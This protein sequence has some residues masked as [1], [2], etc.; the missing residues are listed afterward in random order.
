MRQKDL[1]NSFPRQLKLERHRRAWSQARLAELLATD[2]KTV[3]RWERGVALPA[4]YLREHLCQLLDKTPQELG[5]L[6]EETLVATP[7][8][9]FDPSIPLPP[10]ISL[11]GR[12]EEMTRLK[13]RLRD[14]NSIALAALNG[15]PGVGKTA[16][17]IAL[18]HDPDI[19]AHFKDGILWAGLGPNPNI[20]S[21]VSRWGTLLDMSSSE[22]NKL[23]GIEA[24]AEAL[25]RIIGLRTML[26]VIDDAWTPESALALKVGGPTCAHLVTTRLPAVA[27]QIAVD[28][29]ITIG[30]LHDEE[31]LTLLRALAPQ[32]VEKEG[33][34]VRELL[35]AVGGLPLAL[36]LIGNYLRVQS[37]TGQNRRILSALQRLSNT[38]ERLN[39]SAPH[40]PIE[41]HPSHPGDT[42]LSLHTIIA[43]SDQRLDSRARQAFYS[44]AAF[45]AKPNSFSEEAALAVADCPVEVLDLLIDAGLLESTSSDRYT[46]H[47]TIAD[48]ALLQLSEATA[49]ERLITYIANFV[50]IHR[51]DYEILESESNTIVAAL[52]VATEQERYVGLIRIICSL[53]PF[54]LSRG[55]YQLAEAHLHR[56]YDAAITQNDHHNLASILFYL[57]EMLMKQGQYE[58]AVQYLQ[59]GLRE[60]RG[61]GDQSRVC[62]ILAHLGW[63]TWKKGAIIQAEAYL[64]EG[65]T[66][67]RQF[68]YQEQA[69]SLLR[70][71][72]SVS[73]SQGNYAQ[74]E[75]YLRE[76][77]ALASQLRD[78]EQR[79]VLL[80]DLGVT[81]TV[82]GE[83]GQAEQT[84]LEAL[85]IARQLGHQEW[86]SLSLFN[87]G[88]ILIDQQRYTRAKEVFL[89]GLTLAQQIHHQE[90]TGGLLINLGNVTYKEN[91]SQAERAEYYFQEGLRVLHHLPRPEFLAEALDVY[92]NFLLEQAQL[93]QAEATFQEMLMLIPEKGK[94]LFMLAWYGL[95]RVAAMRKNWEQ[96][97]SYGLASLQ[98]MEET[99]H[100]L[101]RE[102]SKWLATL[103]LE[104][105]DHEIIHH[106]EDD[107]GP[108]AI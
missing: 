28:G 5:L 31:S 27:A 1:I 47:Q 100:R 40:G 96:A 76:G 13:H 80:I 10:N 29:I 41:H 6:E 101:E 34:R 50:E 7:P 44:L 65:L 11:V 48:Y 89:E 22:I 19:R 25:H 68:L 51:K 69:C 73:H 16:L 104:Q 3:S 82:Q 52:A 77:I 39:I 88:D 81:L 66:L 90:W 67:A 15:L 36:H 95:A 86:M 91:A 103:S 14:G 62:M 71:L 78:R 83:S 53:A 46:L 74:A 32:A 84:L 30:E 4:S 105:Q 57:G 26:L 108:E 98:A 59:E 70:V 106:V 102:V 61:I 97:H 18:A 9:L 87:L 94:S 92:G 37:Y 43:V 24:W 42:H 17:A 60:A 72:G 56:A 12:D 54:L 33:Q 75:A 85:Q 21:H 8:L 58:Q 99:G 2:T 107:T 23:N 38:G 20:Q 49:H 79:C 45:P 35:T 64:Q 63:V 55:L 93:E